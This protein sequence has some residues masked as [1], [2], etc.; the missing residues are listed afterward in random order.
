MNKLAVLISNKGTGTNL[1]AIIDAIQKKQLNAQIVCV[2]S[3]TKDALALERARKSKLKIAIS[4]KK[5]DLLPLL[6]KYN[7]DYICLA[8]WKQFIIEEVIDAYPDRIINLHPGLIP[9]TLN[10]EVKNPDGT[11]ALW[12][13]GKLADVAVQNFLDQK[14]TYAGSS[15]HFLTH[16]FDF[17]PVLERA[18][19]KTTKNDTVAS[20]YKRLKE[21]ENEIY[22]KALQKLSG[23]TVL[24]IDRGGR[25]AALVDKY[26]HSSK[27]GRVLATLENDPLLKNVKKPLKI[28]SEVK[29]TDINGIKKIIK[30][31]KVDFVDVAQD[32]AVAA[33]VTDALQSMN[34]KVFGPTKAAGQIEWDKAWAR[35]F[36]KANKIPIPA[37]K[38]C[39]TESEGV[40]FINSQKDSEW[41][42]KASGLARGKGV[43][44]GANNKE[45]KN[46]ILQMKQFG[47]SGKIY[48]LEQCL[49]GEEFS[50]FA[51]VDGKDFIVLGHAQDHKRAY[52]GDQGPN[53]GGMGC[54]SPPMAITPKIER[55]IEDIFKKAATGLVTSKRPYV[56][57]LYL[58]GMIDKFGKVWVIEFNARWGDPEAQIVLPSIQNDL[59]ELE[60]QV[61]SGL[62]KKIN[63]KKDNLYRVVVTAAAKGY[64]DDYSKVVGKRIS[65]MDK[66]SS[67]KVYGAGVKVSDGK[68]L[69]SGGRLFYIVGAGKN[70][71]EAR[72]IAYNALSKIQVGGGNLHYRKDIGYRDLNRTK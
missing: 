26:L 28:F 5:E 14:A 54:S 32:D 41:F 51:L 4:S 3:D 18:F 70:V 48:L 30:D 37:F 17:G 57:V 24:V 56:G 1:Q 33:G 13:K 23:D 8:G 38:I 16:E 45:A 47:K 34:V 49:H 39:K 60:Q 72:K 71:Q 25:G 36:M 61:I 42:I 43:I 35:N 40:K 64:P 65:G 11:M 44:Y 55:Q 46:A 15:I 50:S 63:L 52:D 12:N 29:T 7:P 58:G 66:T 53:T 21:K 69:A 19:V 62:I 59:Y 9:E 10:G 20:L 31:Y 67:A 6:K 68:Y 27:V 2:I 22:V